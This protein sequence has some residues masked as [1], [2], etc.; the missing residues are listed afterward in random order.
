MTGVNK[1]LESTL[2]K[3][4]SNCKL[5]G[6]AQKLR[7]IEIILSA[8]ITLPAMMSESRIRRI[9]NS[10]QRHALLHMTNAIQVHLA[11]EIVLNSISEAI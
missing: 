2:T 9:S 10:E 8:S 6:Q 4:S 11:E 5:R 3:I 7:A 1:M